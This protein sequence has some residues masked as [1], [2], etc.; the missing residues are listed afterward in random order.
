MINC[1]F[2]TFQYLQ[3]LKV[4]K[5]EC[6]TAATE[7]ERTAI[8]RQRYDIFVKELNFFAPTDEIKQLEY[9]QY[10]PYSLLIGVWEKN[11]LIASCRLILPNDTLGFPTLNTLIIDSKKLWSNHLTAEISRI[12][13]ASNNRSFK[14]TIK[15][16]QIMQQ[17]IY[18]ISVD[19]GIIQCI[20]AVEVPFLKLL[21]YANLPY[22]PIGPLQH[23][24]GPDRYPVV[25]IIDDYLAA[26][27]KQI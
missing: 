11:E 20:G 3:W 22:K 8:L 21:H 12:T 7:I 24:I 1:F 4:N 16:L 26:L 6:T 9:D 19:R 25:L 5:V 2:T 23:H 14:K 13:V 15:V 10:D 17:K 27:K 18:E